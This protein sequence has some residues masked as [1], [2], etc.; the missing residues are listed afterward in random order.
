M[1]QNWLDIKGR[2]IRDPK[3]GHRFGKSYKALQKKRKQ[4]YQD[5]ISEQSTDQYGFV[6]NGYSRNLP[7]QFNNNHIGIVII[8]GSSAMGLGATANSNTI[9]AL[10]EKNVYII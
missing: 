3:Y 6:D 4:G 2:Y 7:S 10:L 1:T 5:E 8:G 9:A